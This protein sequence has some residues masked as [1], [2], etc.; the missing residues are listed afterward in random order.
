MKQV[1]DCPLDKMREPLAGGDTVTLQD[2]TAAGSPQSSLLSWLTGALG[3][4]LT[5]NCALSGSLELRVYQLLL[6]G[7]HT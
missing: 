6:I 1:Q 2:C 3:R 7:L 5:S 4:L